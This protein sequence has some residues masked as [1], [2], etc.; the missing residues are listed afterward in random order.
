MDDIAAFRRAVVLL[1]DK[2]LRKSADLSDAMLVDMVLESDRDSARDI[3]G[4]CCRRLLNARQDNDQ[5]FIALLL[6]LASYD[7]TPEP[8]LHR[9]ISIE[10]LAEALDFVDERVGVLGD[11]FTEYLKDRINH[12]KA[13][14]PA[15]L[16]EQELAEF[17]QEYQPDWLGQVFNLTPHNDAGQPIDAERVADVLDGMKFI[18]EALPQR[19]NRYSKTFEEHLQSF[20][21]GE[22][23][24]LPSCIERLI[25]L[26]GYPI[27]GECLRPIRES[28]ATFTLG[29]IERLRGT[30]H[31]PDKVAANIFAKCQDACIKQVEALLTRSDILDADRVRLL[32]R[33]EVLRNYG[34]ESLQAHN[35]SGNAAGIARLFRNQKDKIHSQIKRSPT[36]HTCKETETV[37]AEV[38]HD[39][40]RAIARGHPAVQDAIRIIRSPVVGNDSRATLL[41]LQ[42]QTPRDAQHIWPDLWK[43]FEEALRQV[44]ANMR[45]PV[46]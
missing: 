20:V 2:S 4:E 44:T 30:D 9:Q 37:F 25:K 21:R 46:K 26:K 43:Q 39:N 17:E 32:E 7:W 10:L 35:R 40:A 1:G 8:N 18:H 29:E 12:A 15:R 38:E 13:Q 23:S 36:V 19:S 28:L 45:K 6:K 24:E 34:S 41:K 16:A 33:R 42:K 11:E 31:W 27:T 14:H 5:T 3:L 22:S